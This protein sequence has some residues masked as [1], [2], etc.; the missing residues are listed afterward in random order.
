MLIILSRHSL[1]PLSY[2]QPISY[3]IMTYGNGLYTSWH[4]SL[5]SDPCKVI[6]YPRLHYSDNNAEAKPRRYTTIKGKLYMR[7]CKYLRVFLPTVNRRR[8]DLYKVCD[9]KVDE[10]RGGMIYQHS[11]YLKRYK[12][13]L[14]RPV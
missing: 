1:P 8:P 5:K 3:V 12:F 14:R 7:F 11:N 6:L 9:R 13:L 2:T 10:I 4:G